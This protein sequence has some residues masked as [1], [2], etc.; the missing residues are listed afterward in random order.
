MVES[1]E[2]DLPC[3]GFERVHVQLDW[4]DGPRGGL[5]DVEGVAHY[6]RAVHDYHHADE[7]DDEYFV[8]PASTS[9]LALER[10]QRAIFVGWNARYE[11]GAAWAEHHPGNGG[12]DARYD[13]LQALHA[14]HRVMPDDARR[15]IAE[16]GN[17]NGLVRWRSER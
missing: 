4:Y 3:A 5:A 2:E 8:W 6:F 17:G 10:E 14:P 15:M 9:A 7:P 11:V 16:W 1:A 13:E 12:I